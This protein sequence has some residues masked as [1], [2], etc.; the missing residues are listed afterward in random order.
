[1]VTMKVV[2]T[3]PLRVGE[4]RAQNEFPLIIQRECTLRQLLVQENQEMIQWFK[5][6]TSLKL[7]RRILKNATK[8]ETFGNF[9]LVSKMPRVTQ[10]M[11]QKQ[12]E[13][14][15]SKKTR[16]VTQP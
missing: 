2:L 14:S 6:S 4:N 16:R 15:V 7:R 9:S 1:M 5:S 3:F 10:K 11:T 12:S 13:I 8:F